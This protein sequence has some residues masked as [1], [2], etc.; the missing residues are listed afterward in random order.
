MLRVKSQEWHSLSEKPRG[1]AQSDIWR[2]TCQLRHVKRDITRVT[3]CKGHVVSDISTINND[4]FG[5][6]CQ[7]LQVKCDK[8]IVTS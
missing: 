6:T 8:S 4:K 1:D 7:T 5:L 3:Y 2:V